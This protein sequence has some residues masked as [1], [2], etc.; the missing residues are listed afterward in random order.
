MK[1]LLAAVLIMVIGITIFA[2]E[3]GEPGEAPKIPGIPGEVKLPMG[4][5]NIHGMVLTGIRARSVTQEGLTNLG[6]SEDVSGNWQVDAIN[7]IW[8]ENRF[9]LHLDYS[10]LNYGAFMTLRLQS[11]AANSFDDNGWPDIRYAFVYGKFLDE[12]IKVSLGKLTDEIYIMPETRLWKTEGPWDM[13]NFTE[14][15]KDNEHLSMRLEVKPIPQLNVGAQYFFAL[16]DGTGMWDKY[17]NKGFAD[18]GAWKEIGLAAEWKSDLFNAVA[19]IRFDSDGDPLNKYEGYTYLRGY[20]GDSDYLGSQAARIA[21]P[22]YKHADDVIGA[23]TFPGAASGDYTPVFLSDPGFGGAA[24]IFF[25]FN[26]KA[27]EKMDIIAQ[28]GFYNIT[29]WENFGYARMNE[30]VRYNNLGV[31]GLGLGLLMSQEF[32]GGDVFYTGD[33]TYDP[34]YQSG[35]IQMINSPFITFAP[36]ISYKVVDVP[37][38][39]LKGAFTGTFGICQDVVDAYIKVKPAV[40]MMLGAF[41]VDLYYEMEYTKYT[42][43]AFG[44]N[45]TPLKPETKNTIGLAVMLMF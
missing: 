9:D 40:N 25:G 41:L 17:W 4:I 12:K 35:D 23:M 20:Y 29:E 24:R 11:W 31:K 2:Q 33:T 7:P 8:A 28:A 3:G 6:Q 32:Y 43:K 1:K 16:P 18:S 22:R 45:N 30:L 19:G 36:E 15:A 42:D 39:Q 37:G 34:L 14:D 13:Y 44:R 5:L 26:V 21:G 38:F 27:V 10:F